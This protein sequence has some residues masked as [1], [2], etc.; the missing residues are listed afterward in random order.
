MGTP[1]LVDGVNLA[2]LSACPFLEENS[3]LSIVY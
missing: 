3:L 2:D 1:G